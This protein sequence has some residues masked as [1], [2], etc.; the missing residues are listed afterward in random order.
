MNPNDDAI[1]ENL[2]F[3]ISQPRTGST[4]VQNILGGHPAIFTLQEPWLMLHPL[5]DL[6]HSGKAKYEW[7][8]ANNAVQKLLESLPNGTA[9]YFEAV[10]RMYGY[11]Y[12]RALAASGKQVFLDKTPRYYF[13]IPELKL[14]FPKARFIILFRNPLA[15][16]ISIIKSWDLL[17]LFQYKEDLLRAPLLLLNGSDHLMDGRVVVQYEKFI[18]A[19]EYELRRICESINLEFKPEILEYKNRELDHWV[20]GDRHGIL[21]NNNRPVP[22]HSEKWIQSLDNPQVWRLAREYLQALGPEVISR[23]GYAYEELSSLLVS[24]HPTWIQ[25]IFTL[26]MRLYLR[27]PSEKIIRLRRIVLTVKQ[28]ITKRGWWRT[29]RLGM[30]RIRGCEINIGDM[31]HACGSGSSR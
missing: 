2:I 1:Y 31:K 9:D 11:L 16:L 8:K 15:V 4:L 29:F 5:Y 21:Q 6:W 30:S 18:A 14:A 3:L 24:K 25:L 22:Q 13:I 12:K 23:M 10:R 27:Q 26:P 19:P 7:D 28:S 17:F 20:F